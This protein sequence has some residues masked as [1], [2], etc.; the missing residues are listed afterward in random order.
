[1]LFKYSAWLVIETYVLETIS[2]PWKTE[3]KKQKLRGE[4]REQCSR[5]IRPIC[6]S[7]LGV[8]VCQAERTEVLLCSRKCCEICH[9]ERTLHA[10]KLCILIIIK[11]LDMFDKCHLHSLSS[12]AEIG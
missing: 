8:P 3:V 7:Q 2:H 5:F 9:E 10:W 4:S 6:P 1:M 11:T 12:R